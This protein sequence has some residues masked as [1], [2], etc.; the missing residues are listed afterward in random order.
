VQVGT[1]HEVEVGGL[2]VSNAGHG[3]DVV[4]DGLA[5]RRSELATS[6]V[7]RQE[8]QKSRP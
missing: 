1:V 6:R 4:V 8:E 2:R 7:G 5:G 3:D